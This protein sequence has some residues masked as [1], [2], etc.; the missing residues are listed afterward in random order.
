MFRARMAD[1]RTLC[2]QLR[3]AHTHWTRMK[4]LL[5]TQTLPEGTGLW[6]RPCNQ[7]H[8]YLMRYAIDVVFLD[9]EQRV[10]ALCEALPVNTISPKVKAATS[11]L[12]LPVGS[13]GRFGLQE[14]TQ[15]VI[16]GEAAPINE[17]V[18]AI[19]A[20]SSN[21]LMAGLYGLFFWRHINIVAGRGEWAT[22]LPI[23]IQESLLV[24]FFL[25]R[26]R[27]KETSSRPI[28]WFVAICGTA[29][30]L[31]LRPTPEMSSY[32]WIGQPLQMLGLTVAVFGT[33]SLGRSIGVVPSNRGVQ[34]G[35]LHSFVRHPMY[36]GYI[37]GYLGYSIVYPST[38]NL[39]LF[40]GTVLALNGRII[41]EESLLS[42]DPAYR[43]Y[44]ERVRWRLLPYVY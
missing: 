10:V 19:G 31:F 30:P 14:G 5:G 13:I 28:E 26:R 1:G 32:A 41:A 35:S 20:W 21:L 4:G 6:I 2:S 15:L 17:T 37:V 33:M 39:A 43:D 27:S 12:E 3:P 7:V 42:R 34:T 38:V 36:A 22:A 25:A 16:D 8:M 44:R 9:A 24:F 11:V 23:L 40:V 18:Q 29:L